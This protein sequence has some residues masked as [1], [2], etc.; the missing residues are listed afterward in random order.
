[1]FINLRL[2]RKV[3]SILSFRW[4]FISDYLGLFDFRKVWHHSVLITTWLW[5]CSLPS[6]PSCF[7]AQGYGT[8]LSPFSIL[9]IKLIHRHLMKSWIAVFCSQPIAHEL[10]DHGPSVHPQPCLLPWC[11]CWAASIATLDRCRPRLN[12]AWSKFVEAIKSELW[13]KTKSR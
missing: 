13:S 7:V 9:P 8:P 6:S 10:T 1:M 5:A 2:F 3:M 11:C 12:M 4:Y